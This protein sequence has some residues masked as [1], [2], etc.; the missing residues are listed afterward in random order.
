MVTCSSLGTSPCGRS[1]AGMNIHSDPM[2]ATALWTLNAFLR[3]A[4][5]HFIT[6]T[7]ST[8]ERVNRRPGNE[9]A[10]SLVD[11]FG[12]SR[13]FAQQL[14]PEQVFN[15]LMGGGALVEG[16]AGWRSLIRASSLDDDI[17]FH[18]SFP[19]NSSDAVFF[20][21]DTYRFARAIKANL[22]A[23]RL[24]RRAL[25]L[26]C[27]AGAGGIVLA[28]NSNCVDLVL[29]DINEKALQLA[30][31]N[32]EAAGLRNVETVHSDLFE[33]LDGDFDLIVA[34]PPYLNDAL[35]RTYRHGGGELGSELSYRIA[36]G[37]KTRLARDG[38]LLLYTGSPIVAGV[39]R[40]KLA[41][42]EMFSTS[43]RFLW[44]YEEIDPDVFGEDLEQATYAHVDRIA[45]IL[46]TVKKL[47]AP[48][49]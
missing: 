2:S 13:P 5:Y 30:G 34:N 36:L 26:G 43:E 46:L 33:Q 23:S 37:A 17:L 22:T 3:Q 44:S 11:I 41:V 24:V 4:R 28:K 48:Q 27:G 20:G 32:A 18:S 14:L 19:T 47:E 39:D 35:V 38:V 31:F 7:P 8:H 10:R 25:D 45:A 12:W 40:F 16:S 9:R 29:S 6:S 42:A 21:P 15:A 1:L 49:C